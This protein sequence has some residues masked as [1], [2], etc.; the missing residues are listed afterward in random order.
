MGF[1]VNPIAQVVAAEMISF[2]WIQKKIAQ[3]LLNYYSKV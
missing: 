1:N 2:C 3:L